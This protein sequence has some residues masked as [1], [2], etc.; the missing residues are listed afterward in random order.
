MHARIAHKKH[1][2]PSLLICRCGFLA[3]H[4][5]R[6]T[7][8][9]A[10][11]RLANCGPLLPSLSQSDVHPP[12]NVTTDDSSNPGNTPMDVCSDEDE[13]TDPTKLRA[14]WVLR[15]NDAPVF[16]GGLIRDQGGGGKTPA[17]GGGANRKDD[18]S[19]VAPT[20][21]PSPASVSLSDNESK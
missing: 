13:G 14:L 2:C 5:S 16:E 10:V 20:S 3:K 8:H 15:T 12:R 9:L 6:F 7:R 17:P 21:A 18:E 11:T 1:E 19:C 4:Q